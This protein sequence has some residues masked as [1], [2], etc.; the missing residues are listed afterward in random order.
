MSDNGT[1]LLRSNTSAIPTLTTTPKPKP[2]SCIS[3][4][5][6]QPA[7]NDSQMEELL[8]M[9]KDVV[10]IL[11]RA[12]LTYMMFAGT[13]LGSY[14]HHGIIPWDVDVDLQLDIEEQSKLENAFRNIPN[15]KYILIKHNPPIHWKVNFPYKKFPFVDLFFYYHN[16]SHF[17]ENLGYKTI[18]HVISDIFPLI[19][20]P[21]SGM[22]LYAPRNTSKVLEKRLGDIKWCQTPSSSC[23]IHCS[24]IAPWRPF[25]FRNESFEHFINN[26]SVKIERESLI[27]NGTVLGVVDIEILV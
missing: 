10:N 18:V 25:V 27:I 20:R 6:N 21:F 4:L 26:G 23:L 2:P 19:R 24:D 17:G 3:Q 13:L 8:E 11:E 5:L 16:I 9:T 15:G 12:D 14:R 1:T 7:L 22:W